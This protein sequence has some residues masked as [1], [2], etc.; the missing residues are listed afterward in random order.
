MKK[1]LILVALLSGILLY[2]AMNYTDK[3]D[4]FNIFETKYEYKDEFAILNKSFKRDLKRSANLYQSFEKYYVGAES[5]PFYIIIPEFDVKLFQNEFN[6]L[7]N[8]NKIL[9]TPIF[10]TEDAL[11]TM[12]GEPTGITYNGNWTQQVVKLCFGMTNLAKNYFS[13]DS[14]LYFTSE[15]S[16]RSELFHKD[17]L[18]VVSWKIPDSIL[19]EYKQQKLYW[20]GVD[21]EAGKNGLSNSSYES[22]T[23]V[24]DF[25][26]NKNS[27][28]YGFVHGGV[29]ISS[30]VI[31]RMRLL[32]EKKGGYNFASLIR[33]IPFE[34]QWYGEYVLQ[35]EKFY[36]GRS[37]FTLINSPK[38]CHPAISN[39]TY[40]H[41]FQSMIYDYETHNP[42]ID[43]DQI[44]YKRPAHC[45]KE[46]NKS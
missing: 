34:M 11:L 12:C 22:M 44:I 30:D 24:K 6:D 19:R 1:I 42:A 4:P 26:G 36:M 38:E 14:D 35:H 43:N 9:K 16:D 37:L 5:I 15:F 21:H 18:K 45:D 33:I 23:R 7:K 39:K 41:W 29:L 10:I 2:Y 46:L 3:F 25:W 20:F 17:T 31:H 27:T 13:L 40:G 8:K 32:M 28:Y